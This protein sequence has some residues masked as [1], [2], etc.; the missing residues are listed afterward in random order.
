MKIRKVL[1]GIFSALLCVI[2]GVWLYGAIT[3]GSIN[4]FTLIAVLLIAL[5]LFL[6]DNTLK[7]LT[8]PRNFATRLVM[9]TLLVVLGFYVSQYIAT[10]ITFSAT[11]LGSIDAG[12]LVVRSIELSETLSLVVGCAIIAL[13]YDIFNELVSYGK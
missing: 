9:G 10:G 5:L 1:G 11:V 8:I 7:F 4:A 12:I 6:T 3:I 2:S 13:L